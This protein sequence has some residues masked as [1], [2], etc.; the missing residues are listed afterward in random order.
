[1][2]MN[3]AASKC[4]LF[5][6]AAL[7]GFTQPLVI[8]RGEEPAAAA[9][10]PITVELWVAE[11]S[12][13]ALEGMGFDTNNSQ[14]KPD[15]DVSLLEMFQSPKKMSP[16]IAGNLVQVL[17]F[18]KTKKFAR[19]LAEPMLTSRSGQP[20]S[21]AVGPLRF[22][23]TPAIKDDGKIRVSYKVE[24][25]TKD[26]KLTDTVTGVPGWRTFR[27]D[28]KIDDIE[29]SQAAIVAPAVPWNAFGEPSPGKTTDKMLIVVLRASPTEGT[30]DAAAVTSQKG[31]YVETAPAKVR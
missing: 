20:A 12:V 22:D 10:P 7:V 8:V 11:L 30:A 28:S 1:M 21:L 5:F 2:T 25:S 13:P 24:I 15:A 27:I 9:S 23:A 31:T 19:I 26:P 3:H 16:A 4:W 6:C 17:E 14:L 18:L 29:P